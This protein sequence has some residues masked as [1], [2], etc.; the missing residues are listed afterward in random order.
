MRRRA[1]ALLA[2]AACAA[3]GAA[4]AE[5]DAP[6]CAEGVRAAAADGWAERLARARAFARERRGRVAFALV[7]ERGR[8]RRGLRARERFSAA[9]LVKAMLLVAYLD[10]PAV[11]RRALTAAEAEL[12][13]A[14]VRRSSNRAASQVRDVVGNAGLRRVAR[15]AR[16]RDFATAPSWGSAR[17]T[18]ADQARLFFR[19]DRLVPRRHRAFARALLAGIVRSQ[20]WGLAQ[21]VPE[22]WTAYFKGGWRPERGARL[23]HQA[24]LLRRRGTRIALAVLTDGQPWHGYGALTIRGIARRLLGDGPPAG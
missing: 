3:G 5:A 4:E 19:V 2:V 18:A 24:A 12:L 7:D 21:A 14:M 20:R 11:A 10:R 23:V 9:S 13:A 17:V 16:M 8:L 15:R 22:G 6:A 1:A